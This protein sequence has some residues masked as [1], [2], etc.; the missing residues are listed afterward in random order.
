MKQYKKIEVN[1]NMPDS[2]GNVPSESNVPTTKME[3]LNISTYFIIWLLGVFYDSIF[4][5]SQTAGYWTIGKGS[6]CDL[7]QSKYC[8]SCI[9]LCGVI[10]EDGSDIFQMNLVL[11]WR[12]FRHQMNLPMFQ[13]IKHNKGKIISYFCI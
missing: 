7:Y 8:F 3:D 6:I 9:I 11:Q 12:S 5:L 4:V 13:N 10:I 1:T 2:P